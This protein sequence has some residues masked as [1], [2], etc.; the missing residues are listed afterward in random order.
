[1]LNWLRKSALLPA[2]LAFSG[3][4]I[5]YVSD[6]SGEEKSAPES[7]E[8]VAEKPDGADAGKTTEVTLKDLK[9]RLPESWKSAPNSSSM[10]LATYVIPAAEGDKEAG[11]L[12]V[13]NFDGGGGDLTAN[14]T[15]WIGQFSSEGRTVELK[16]GK[17]GETMYYVADI[18]GT[19]QKPVGPPILRHTTPA[20]GFRM[21]GVVIELEGKGV[22]YLKL[23]G[24][25]ATV[26]AQAE[27]LRKTFGGSADGEQEY[28]I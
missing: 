2:V 26:T 27:N 7:T 4:A 13:F 25:D 1:M 6:V 9:L 20:K 5:A 11:E 14:L 3:I 22:Y 8:P 21:L 28:Q 17:A 12:T 19:Y 10:R 16:K 18:A 15:R 24:P 23:V